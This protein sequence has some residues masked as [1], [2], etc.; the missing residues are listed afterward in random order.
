MASRAAPVAAKAPAKAAPPKA[1][2][3]SIGRARACTLQMKCACGSPSTAGVCP[4]CDDKKRGVLSRKAASPGAAISVPSLVGSVLSSPGR[5]L[6]PATRS[7]MESKFGQDLGNVR[8]HTDS[9]AAESARA[10]NAHAYTVG[11]NIVFDHGKYDPVSAGG[12][13]LLAHELTHTVQQAGLQRSPAVPLQVSPEYSSLEIE[14][15]RVANAVSSGFAA[16]SIHKGDLPV[17]SRTTGDQ[18][19]PPVG[20]VQ[21]TTTPLPVSGSAPSGSPPQGSAPS[22]PRAIPGSTTATSTPTGLDQSRLTAAGV[23]QVQESDPPNPAARLF[24]INQLDL[25]AIK[26]PFAQAIYQGLADQNQLRSTIDYNGARPSAGASQG[27]DRTRTLQRTWLERVNWR[28]DVAHTYWAQVGGKT[29][30][31][32]EPRL[33]NDVL[34]HMDHIVELQLGGTNAADNV[35]VLDPVENTT[36]GRNLFDWLVDKADQIRDAHPATARPNRI[37]MQFLRVNVTGTMPACGPYT[38]AAPSCIAIEARMRNA[39]LQGTEGQAAP[40]GRTRVRLFAGAVGA[41]AYL[42]PTGTT[43]LNEPANRGVQ[44]IVVG[45]LL[46]SY[47]VG[48]GGQADRATARVDRERFTGRTGR[49]STAI[50]IDITKHPRANFRVQDAG[51]DG[52]APRKNLSFD[53]MSDPLMRFQYP[54]LS[55][56]DL[57]LDYNPQTGFSGTGTLRSDKPLLRNLA[58]QLALG[59]GRLAATLPAN[60]ANWRPLGPARVTR[61]EIG[62]VL[63]PE[64]S[65]QGNL[66]I[67]FGPQANPYAS[68]NLNVTVNA[69]GFEAS[70]TLDAHI[71]RV[72]QARGRIQNRN[73]V[74]SGQI[75]IESTQLRIPNVTRCTV[76]IDLTQTGVRVGGEIVLD[77]RGNPVTLGAHLEGNDWVFTGTGTFNLSPLDPTTLSFRWTRGLLTGAGSTGFTYRG[78]RG[79]FNL[80]YDG[81]NVTGNGTLN[82]N[83]GRMSGTINA[84][85]LRSGAITGDGTIAYQITP[86]LLGTVGIAIDE[87][88][89]VRLTGEIRFTRPIELFRRYGGSR[90]LFSRNLD[91]PILGIS[92]G[93]TSIGLVF[94]ITGALSIDYGIGPGQIQD[95][96]LRGA[97]NP[98]DANPDVELEGGGRLVIPASAGFTASIRGALALSAGIASVSGGVTASARVGLEVNASND[99]SI[100]Y[101]RGVYV[102]DNVARIIA[103]PVLDFGL[104]ANIEAEALGGMYTYHR[105][106]QLASYRLGTGL[107]FGV[108]APFHYASN[109]PF[110]APS[111]DDIRFIRPE[112]DVSSIMRGMLGRVGAA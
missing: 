5:P 91:I 12:R 58:F 37:S 96:H 83:R 23:T 32:F 54:Y 1:A 39:P 85:L 44:Q 62:A 14:A 100:A 108:E 51:T 86:S 105:G 7:S 20:D 99:L 48:A 103:S 15:D 111:L 71:P 38:G 4:S 52:G 73:G 61:A 63:L 107:Q 21:T 24:V 6:D 59:E 43:D 106:Y 88:Q 45:F 56:G 80:N 25:P 42:S 41:N 10:V 29:L 102:V 46:D 97:F 18:S 8:I 75:R 68:A 2:S 34:C 72:D 66:D 98:F 101:R 3:T 55:P 26:G 90:Q 82:M 67:A 13:H 70:G 94:R 84:H 104:E 74:W 35:Q 78:L 95:L 112:L 109:E 40:A 92:L 11:Q 93:V 47:S 22:A 87:R 31:S 19:A 77:I 89:N 17:L 76:V 53:A 27:R 110:R 69:S 33:Q 57:R 65:A 50:P 28:R 79:R 36:S 49:T 9:R 81:E 30:T 16:P 64:I 60:V